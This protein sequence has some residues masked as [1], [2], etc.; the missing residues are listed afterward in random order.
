MLDTDLYNIVFGSGNGGDDIDTAIRL[1]FATGGVMSKPIKAAA[2]TE[3]C[4]APT[5][6]HKV[7]GSNGDSEKSFGSKLDPDIV[8]CDQRTELH[9]KAICHV[10]SAMGML[11]S[12]LGNVRPSDLEAVLHHPGYS[13]QIRTYLGLL[14]RRTS[15]FEALAAIFGWTVESNTP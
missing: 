6:D 11:A 14:Y 10:L 12:A 7:P 4:P 5:E 1:A 2:P 15:N 9:G 13:E 8:V 3:N